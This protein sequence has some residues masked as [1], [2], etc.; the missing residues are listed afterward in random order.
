MCNVYTSAR[1]RIFIPVMHLI[2]FGYRVFVYFVY[3]HIYFLYRTHAHAH[4]Q[5]FPIKTNSIQNCPLYAVIVYKYLL[6]LNSMYRLRSAS[7]HSK[8]QNWYR[9]TADQ[10]KEGERK[11]KKYH[12]MMMVLYSHLLKWREQNKKHITTMSDMCVAVN[13]QNNRSGAFT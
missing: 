1:I 11:R 9:H 2:M 4:A 13:H 3:G 8:K 6:I 12:E 10:G 5:Q 7:M